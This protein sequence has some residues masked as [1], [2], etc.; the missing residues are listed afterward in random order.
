MVPEGI[1]DGGEKNKLVL[2]NYDAYELIY[3]S[4]CAVSLRVP[5]WHTYLDSDQ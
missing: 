3:Q 5:K 2:Y 1:I 4:V